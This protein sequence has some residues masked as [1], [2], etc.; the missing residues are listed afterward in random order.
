MR[1]RNIAIWATALALGTT[2]TACSSSSGES[3]SAGS[4]TV[5]IG[6]TD[7]SKDY[8]T[9]FTDLAAAEGIDVEIQNFTDYQQPNPIL[10]QGGLDA[11]QFQHLLFL[12]NYNVNT[13]EDLTPIGATVIF[14]LGLYTS[15][16]YTSPSE[17]PD[18]GQIAIPND[19][20]NQARALLV[21][22]S[23]GLIKLAD[24][25]NP[26]SSPADI[27]QSASKVTVV[28]VDPNQTA[29]QLQSLDGAVINNNFAADASI[30][31]T[32]AI[33]SDLQDPDSAEAYINVWAVRSEDVDDATL[34]RLVEIYHDPSV[35]DAVVEENKGTALAIDKTPEELQEI[36]SGLEDLIREQG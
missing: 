14:Q 30:D 13:D 12:A 23:A 7:L 22:Q 24:G 18:G 25:G 11:N 31:P 19:V 17:I 32:T 8:W 9:T 28:P 15:K 21:L 27:D 3:G 6:V 29:V 35:I 16:G 26:L 36:L 5:T 1:L 33:Y 10:T 20:T 34:N 2:L 4:E